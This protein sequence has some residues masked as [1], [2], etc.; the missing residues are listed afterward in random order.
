MKAPEIILTLGDIANSL[1]PALPIWINANDTG[2]R[3][4]T[5]NELLENENLN[6]EID[7]ITI[8]GNN[9]LTIEVRQ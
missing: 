6:T 5:L 3:Y 9:E 2:T 8:D 7:Y 4:E 1:D